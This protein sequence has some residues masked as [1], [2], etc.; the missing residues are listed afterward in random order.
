MTKQEYLESLDK[1]DMLAL[2]KAGLR[3][4]FNYI[5][6]FQSYNSMLAR[7]ERKDGNVASCY[8]KKYGGAVLY[9]YSNKRWILMTNI[10]I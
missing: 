10:P 6:S 9:C 1:Q 4:S 8:V 5:G 7:A 2:I 3:E